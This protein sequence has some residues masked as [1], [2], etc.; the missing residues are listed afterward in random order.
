MTYYVGWDAKP[1]L[2]AKKTKQH[3]KQGARP[4]FG[5]SQK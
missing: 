2:L 5:T 4:H 3:S 1:Y